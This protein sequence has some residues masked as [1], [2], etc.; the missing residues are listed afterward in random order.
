MGEVGVTD[1]R[2]VWGIVTHCLISSPRF[3]RRK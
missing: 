1:C 3:T 2:K